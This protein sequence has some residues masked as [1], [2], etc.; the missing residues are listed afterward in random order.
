MNDEINNNLIQGY[1]GSRHASTIK[2]ASMM[3]K[4]GHKK[5]EVF[6]ERI[7][8]K[9]LRG[10]KKPDVIKGESRY[11]VKGAKA[12]IQLDLMSLQKSENVY[13]LSSPLYKFQLCGYKLRKFKYENDN[14]VDLN[15]IN[16]WKNSSTSA[17]K[18]LLKKNN[19]RNVIEK[20][21]L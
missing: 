5:E 21:F 14:L 18:W 13:G 2:G 1:D 3:K 11:S 9:V 7:G 19:F 17:R 8:G 6:A 16:I 12:N 15:L 20:V 4:I 10:R